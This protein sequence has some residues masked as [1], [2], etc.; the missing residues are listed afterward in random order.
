MLVGSIII[1]SPVTLLT[2]L[3]IK[4]L[5]ARWARQK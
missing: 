4:R 2:Y 1:A 3:V 5:A